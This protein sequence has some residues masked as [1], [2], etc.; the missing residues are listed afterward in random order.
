MLD[1]LLEDLIEGLKLR[2]EEMNGVFNMILL[3]ELVKVFVDLFYFI[4]IFYNLFDNVIKYCEKKLNICIEFKWLNKRWV[5]LS[6]EDNGIGIKKE[7]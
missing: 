1:D 2:V 6:I 7:Y 4:N 5:L 3:E